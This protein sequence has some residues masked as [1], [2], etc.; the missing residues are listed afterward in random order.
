MSPGR[1]KLQHFK[2]RLSYRCQ[3]RQL[4]NRNRELL[5]HGC[6]NILSPMINWFVCRSPGLELDDGRSRA[7][8]INPDACG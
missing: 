4:L 7:T 6:P 3:E 8:Y 5:S 2:M 1:D